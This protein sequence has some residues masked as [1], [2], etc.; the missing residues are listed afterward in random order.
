[1]TAVAA[2]TSFSK[3]NSR[4]DMNL[5]GHFITAVIIYAAQYYLLASIN[6]VDFMY[7]LWEDGSTAYEIIHRI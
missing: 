3:A 5:F 7:M 1:M 4:K 6:I 2:A